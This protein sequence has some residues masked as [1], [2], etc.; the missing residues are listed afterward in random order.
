MGLVGE[1]GCGKSVTIRSILGLV[2]PPGRVARGSVE[3]AEAGNLLSL[4]SKSWRRVRGARIGFVPQSPFA[5]LNP[6]LKIERQFYNVLRAHRSVS[7]A[8]ARATALDMLERMGIREPDRVLAGHAHE[9]SG[10]MAQR[11]VIALAVMLDPELIIADEPTTALDV[12]VQKRI[13]E[14]LLGVVRESDR[15]MLLVT[16]DLGVVA[17]YCERI[18]VM[19]AG[20]IVEEGTVGEVFSDPAH[21]YTQG[22]LESVPRRGHE[23]RS[24]PGRVPDLSKPIEGCAFRDRCRHVHDACDVDPQLV[25]VS[26]GRRVS[27]HLHQGVRGADQRTVE[28]PAT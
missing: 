18:A 25:S 14:L 12:T 6:I 16:H 27:C 5:A 24:L 28:E 17:H 7:R 1:S 26:P 15:A 19:Y 20:R 9:L 13:L 23:I 8:E 2:P 11:V 3:M 10:G 4:S 21:P 22:L